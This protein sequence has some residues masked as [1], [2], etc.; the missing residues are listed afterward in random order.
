[1]A[2]RASKGPEDVD[3]VVERELRSVVEEP[4]RSPAESEDVLVFWIW[5]AEKSLWKKGKL[6]SG[7][8]I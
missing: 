6:R 4:S 3:G 5:E 8:E 2:M 1:M 7:F